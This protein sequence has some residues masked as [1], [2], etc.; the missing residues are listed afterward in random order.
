[1][2]DERGKED[3]LYSSS[4]LLTLALELEVTGRMQSALMI[5]GVRA[6]NAGAAIRQLL[7]S[8]ERCQ[9][10][11]PS[12]TSPSLE[13]N[14]HLKNIERLLERQEQRLSKIEAYFAGHDRD[15]GMQDLS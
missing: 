4:D 15:L 8:L 12:Y 6:E 11:R 3:G 2:T 14:A 5:G 7:Q 10:K 13:T 1:M 9:E